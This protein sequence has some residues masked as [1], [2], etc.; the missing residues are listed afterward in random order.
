[1][2]FFGRRKREIKELEENKNRKLLTSMYVLIISSIIL[3]IGI[4][5]LAVL[6]LEEGPI[7]GAIIF[8]ATAFVIIIAFYALKLEMDAGYYECKNCHHRYVPTS[9]LKVMFAPHIITTRYM[10]CPKCGKNSWSK[11]VLS[12]G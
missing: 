3:Y 2:L 5:L 1:M 6:Y 8:S 7:L 10:K 9:Y 11:K 4:V 12:R